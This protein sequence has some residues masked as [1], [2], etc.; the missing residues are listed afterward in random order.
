MFLDSSVRSIRTIS[1][2]LPA[3]S[4]S[5]ATLAITSGSAARLLISAASTPSG[6]TPI[7]VTWPW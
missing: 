2:R 5:V 1:F 4:A 7:P 3:A 6:C